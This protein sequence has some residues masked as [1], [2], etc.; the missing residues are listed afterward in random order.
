MPSK[1]NE[2]TQSYA[3]IIR[4]WRRQELASPLIRHSLRQLVVSDPSSV[5]DDYEGTIGAG[6]PSTISYDSA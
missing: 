4:V 3:C 5:D 6:G 2:T 1:I